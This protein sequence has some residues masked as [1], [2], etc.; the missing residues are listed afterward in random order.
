MADGRRSREF[1]YKPFLLPEVHQ[2]VVYEKGDLFNV[3]R[4][5]CQYK[6]YSG[7][8]GGR[9]PSLG[10]GVFALEDIP[11]GRAVFEYSGSRHILSFQRVL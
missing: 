7:P 1:T 4:T 3:F 10:Y 2:N 5:G 6:V 8:Y 11:K 9:Y